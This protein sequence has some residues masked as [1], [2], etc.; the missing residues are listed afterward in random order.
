MI[1]TIQM[2]YMVRIIFFQVI[3]CLYTLGC[4]FQ[5]LHY[6]G[7]GTD[8]K[9]LAS[10]Q[11]AKIPNR[12]GQ[13]L[14]SLLLARFS[15]K[16]LRVDPKYILFVRLTEGK[17]N[18]AIRKDETATRANLTI[19]ADYTLREKTTK[20]TFLSGQVGATNSYNILTSE[21][22]TMTAE[23]NA[24]DRVLRSLANQIPLRISAKFHE[25][26][27]VQKPHFLPKK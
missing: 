10:I 13:K 12:N 25:I 9:W 26:L 19:T 16:F 24:R 11:I 2:H 15:P 8:A 6:E 4:G 23:N 20:K 5:P 1:H 17:V 18:L 14:R 22:A 21:F 7:G 27:Q 3:I